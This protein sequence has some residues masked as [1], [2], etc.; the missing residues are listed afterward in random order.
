MKRKIEQWRN[1][2][3]AAMATQSR[4]AVTFAFEDA[5]ADI[6]ALHD[7]IDDIRRVMERHERGEVDSFYTIGWIES[8]L[9]RVE[10]KRS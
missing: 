4:V 7:A 9:A 8:A 1:C 10:D 3:P 6:I 2:E 5:K